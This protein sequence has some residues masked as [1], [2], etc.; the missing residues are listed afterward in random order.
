MAKVRRR[1]ISRAAAAGTALI[2]TGVVKARN[3]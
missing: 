1:E 3:W 2:G